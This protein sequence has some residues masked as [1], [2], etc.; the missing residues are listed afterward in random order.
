MPTRA[1]VAVV[2]VICGTFAG[3]GGWIATHQRNR[4]EL[5]QAKKTAAEALSA[6]AA[7]ATDLVA[8]S[9]R[10]T[11]VQESDQALRGVLRQ[12]TDQYEAS[13]KALAEKSEAL[14]DLR[15]DPR[16]ARTNEDSGFSNRFAVV[17]DSAAVGDLRITVEASIIVPAIWAT[18]T[19]N[20]LGT[21]REAMLRATVKIT[22]TSPTKKF[23]YRSWRD[24]SFG[25]SDSATLTDVHCN[26]YRKVDFG[27]GKK[28]AG[29]EDEVGAIYPLKSIVEVLIFEKPVD[30]FGHL[31][32]KLP[33]SNLGE[34]GDLY[35][36]I[37]K[38][39]VDN[40]P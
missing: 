29:A 38:D 30:T 39:V 9:S 33:L 16:I 21:A 19:N 2:A 31:L 6:Q 15:A 24:D 32:L 5:E 26:A 36:K 35:F 11:E 12:I 3:M 8:C 22:N 14:V 25:R 27:F 1:I 37:P 23:D 20:Y 7:S 17:P 10:L 28:P 40:A 13:E 18:G 34:C 4:S